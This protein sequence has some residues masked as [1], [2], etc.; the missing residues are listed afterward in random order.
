MNHELIAQADPLKEKIERLR[1]ENQGGEQ[2]APTPKPT[3]TPID[4]EQFQENLKELNKPSQF[5][6][7]PVK[8]ETEK[9][10]KEQQED[11]QSNTQKLYEDMSYGDAIKMGIKN[12]PGSWQDAVKDLMALRKKET[13]GAMGQLGKEFLSMTGA[14][15]VPYS[16]HA[17]EHLI[18]RD[19]TPILNSVIQLYA[20]NY[21]SHAGLKRFIAEDPVGFLSDAAILLPYVGLLKKAKLPAKITRQLKGLKYMD[22]PVIQKG[23]E[24]PGRMAD[25]AKTSKGWKWSKRGLEFVADPTGFAGATA[26]DISGWGISRL[27]LFG[28]ADRF[29]TNELQII[30]QHNKFIDGVA[31]QY[32]KSSS[33]VRS[34]EL[35]T[36]AFHT[37]SRKSISDIRKVI[38]D[39][40]KKYKVKL[41]GEF[42]TTNN[43]TTALAAKWKSG[44]KNKVLD[45]FINTVSAFSKGERS[46]DNMINSYHNIVL[47]LN[48]APHELRNYI[49]YDSFM[50]SMLYDIEYTLRIGITAKYTQEVRHKIDSMFANMSSPPSGALDFHNLNS[51]IEDMPSFIKQMAGI[52]V[53]VDEVRAALDIYG[54][55]YVNGVVT[56]D[57]GEIVGS[58]MGYKTGAN[59]KEQLIGLKNFHNSMILRIFERNVDTPEKVVPM[60]V[61]ER[62]VDATDIQNIKMLTEMTPENRAIFQAEVL[63]EIFEQS[64]EKWSPNGLSDAIEKI[65]EQKLQELLD[66]QVYTKLQEIA[67]GAKQFREATDYH[68]WL[69]RL[70]FG[71][72]A[73]SVGGA[74]LSRNW[75]WLLGGLI[76]LASMQ[77]LKG[78]QKSGR[79]VLRK[80]TNWKAGKNIARGT[81]KSNY[82]IQRA[83][84]N[85]KKY[86]ARNATE[87]LRRP[88]Q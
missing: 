87:R 34:G 71:V 43:I 5:N 77:L 56:G 14:M 24:V 22:S 79:Y 17:H 3:T 19:S 15:A 53:T 25:W 31:G 49:D 88:V 29:K 45:E 74:A 55:P 47:Y 83:K 65:G 82:M 11:P 6:I 54:I 75:D 30:Q 66:P 58:I 4:E 36:K 41:K 72:S 16:M 62:A 39:I 44:V 28:I 76:G 20:D 59:L 64:P 51:S 73:F 61:R 10:R 26:V 2:P 42:D 13:W 85:Q 27:P 1:K 7:D 57:A 50:D 23:L 67:E 8:A 70:G 52:E 81:T 84:R 60:I 46:I 86:P 35:L 12:F 78:A 80:P 37:H 40:V 18:D 33:P 9:R 48:N 32:Q 68:Q 69:D 38:K 63:R 21:G